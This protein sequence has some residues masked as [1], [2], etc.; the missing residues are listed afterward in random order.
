M[1]FRLHANPLV[2]FSTDYGS[3][4][5]AELV[6]SR[7]TYR[8]GQ[9]FFSGPDKKFIYT[10]TMI[11]PITRKATCYNYMHIDKCFV[12][13]KGYEGSY[14]LLSNEFTLELSLL[15]LPCP[16]AFKKFPMKY[17]QE[18]ENQRSFSYVNDTGKILHHP[19]GRPAACECR[20]CVNIVSYNDASLKSLS[21]QLTS[22]KI[23][24]VKVDLFS[25]A[26]G[27]SLGME[28]IF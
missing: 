7:K 16:M 25:G 3:R 5:T 8:V 9:S 6:L 23:Q 20:D 1:S 27:M 12:C 28:K 24:F 13:P 21:L 17:S 19:T 22:I 11:H 15:K 4:G 14:V 2:F 10:I 26:G 18:D